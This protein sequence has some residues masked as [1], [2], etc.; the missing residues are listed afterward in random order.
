MPVNFLKRMPKVLFSPDTEHRTR[1]TLLV[2]LV[3]SFLIVLAPV[4]QGFG[5]FTVETYVLTA[6][7]WLLVISEILAPNE[8]GV[9]WW[10]RLVLVRFLGWLVVAWILFQRVVEV[11]A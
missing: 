8:T 10:R 11:L 7:V 4:L 3:V 2:S 9:T 1:L 6:F 5:M